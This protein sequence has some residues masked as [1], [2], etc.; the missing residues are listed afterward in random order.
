MLHLRGLTYDS[1]AWRDGQH[2]FNVAAVQ[3]VRDHGLRF[4]HPV[5]FFVG[6]NGTGKTTVLESIAARY[7]RLGRSRLTST[8]SARP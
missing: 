6:E 1:N 8:P 7:P 4:K 2:P 3:H 5:T